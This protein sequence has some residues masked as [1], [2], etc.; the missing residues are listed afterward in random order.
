DMA[1]DDAEGTAGGDA[2][3]PTSATSDH[4]VHFDALPSEGQV[5][6]IV[7][8]EGLVALILICNACPE[9]IPKITCYHASLIPT[10]VTILSSNVPGVE[11]SMDAEPA[12]STEVAGKPTFV[13]SDKKIEYSDAVKVNVCLLLGAL[14]VADA[15]FKAKVQSALRPVLEPLVRW[16]SDSNLAAASA[17]S[18]AAAASVIAPPS[19]SRPLASL[20]RSGTKS[21]GKNSQVAKLAAAE[22]TPTIVQGGL[23]P[24]GSAEEGLALSEA[25]RRLMAVL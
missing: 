14:V 16:T 18:D 15:P 9:A 12:A 22:R 8:N 2:T 20:S 23:A 6:S 1:I 21:A 19:P 11:P 25:V 24:G 10:V 5:Y 7:Q 13:E 4:H 3:S 17:A